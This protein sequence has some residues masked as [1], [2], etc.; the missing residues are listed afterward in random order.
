MINSAI[1]PFKL[2]QTEFHQGAAAE[3]PE[4]SPQASLTSA[5]LKEG[6]CCWKSYC[7]TRSKLSP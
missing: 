5:A 2:D 1:L 3:R 4:Q 6:L 7:K